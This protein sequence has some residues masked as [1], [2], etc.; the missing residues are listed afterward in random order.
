MQETTALKVREYL[1]R[2][3]PTIIGHRDTDFPNPPPFLLEIPN[4]PTGVA[5]SLDRIADF[6]ARAPQLR[7]PREA[8]AHLDVGVKEVQRLAFI[9]QVARAR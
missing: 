2:G 5:S 8:I 7:V 4:E 1:A 6:V 9:E 3:I